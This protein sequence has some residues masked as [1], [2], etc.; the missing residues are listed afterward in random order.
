MACQYRRTW[1]ARKVGLHESRIARKSDCTKVGLHESRI[2]RKL[3][4]MKVG[5]HE[6][7]IAQKLDCTQ[8]S[9]L[10]ISTKHSHLPPL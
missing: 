4:C 7:R 5:L 9:H 3:D 6:S 10:F 1:I 8:E 2:A